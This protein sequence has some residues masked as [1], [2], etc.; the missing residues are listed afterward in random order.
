M[1]L[2]KTISN[3]SEGLYKDK[4]S[5]FLAFAHP[6]SNEDQV[7]ELV[8]MYRKD[9]HDARHHCFA[10]Q[11]GLSGN[12][13]RANDD[14]E[15]SGTAGKPILGQIHSF[16]VTNVF[17][18]VVRYFG[19]TKLGVGG[20][21]QAYKSAAADALQNAEIIEKTV[22]DYF[23]ISF[24]YETMNDV[25][26][27]IKDENLSIISQNFELKCFIVFCV[28]QRDSER[29]KD[30]FLYLRTVKFDFLYSQ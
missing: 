6:V 11:L 24:N 21:I 19:G 29:V 22:N 1:D 30:V 18:M 17:I 20:L 27:I 3:I 15:P 12:C 7:K 23:K 13:Y 16:D 25:M 26:K 8:Q 28:R 2:Y 4:G 5:K 10:W 9:Y 14:G